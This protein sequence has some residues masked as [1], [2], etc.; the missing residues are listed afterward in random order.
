LYSVA[1]LA[2][3]VDIIE[4]AYLGSKEVT[5][6]FPTYFRDWGEFVSAVTSYVKRGFS[7]GDALVAQAL[8]SAD[9]E[10]FVTWNKKHFEGKIKVLTLTPEECLKRDK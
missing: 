4:H 1:G 3:K 2:D 8:D 7:Y 5:V 10:F 9:V 6:I